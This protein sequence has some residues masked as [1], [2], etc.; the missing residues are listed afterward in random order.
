MQ[1]GKCGKVRRK[2]WFRG[3]QNIEE[4]GEDKVRRK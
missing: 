4:Q 1:R 3:I 2:K